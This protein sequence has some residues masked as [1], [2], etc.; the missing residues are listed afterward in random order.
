MAA[1]ARRFLTR[2]QREKLEGQIGELEEK[3]AGEVV[4]AIASRSVDSTAVDATAAFAT[5][6][7]AVALTWLLGQKIHVSA[8]ESTLALGL[9]AVL[10]LFIG[11]A[12]FGLLL[13]R[14]LPAFGIWF[15]TSEV[16]RHHVEERAGAVFLRHN[17]RR[18]RTGTGVLIYISLQER[19]AEVVADSAIA[20]RVPDDK[21]DHLQELV[22]A[23]FNLQ[24]PVD[25][26]FRA[27]EYAG[28]ILEEHVPASGEP[29]NELPNRVI[30][31]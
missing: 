26:V 23:S 16:R 6:L 24:H 25:G 14:S 28:E 8:A 2:D 19:M 22:Q 20:A 1:L 4:L 27:V 5:G 11:G 10:G 9:P 21:W 12:I 3:T 30:L 31:V 13:L 7:A 29:A 15:A 17:L 18:T